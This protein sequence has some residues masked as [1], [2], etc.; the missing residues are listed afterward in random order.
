MILTSGKLYDSSLQGEILNG[1]ERKINETRERETLQAETV[2]AAVEVLREKILSGEFDERIDK[3]A[4]SGAYGAENLRGQIAQALELLKRENLEYKL[5]VELGLGTGGP[6]EQKSTIR[7]HVLP[8]GTLF[9]IAAGNMDGLPVYS[10]LEGLLTGN[11]NILKLPQADGGLSVEILLELLQIEPGLAPYIHVFD[12]P[13]EDIAAMQKMADMSDGIVVWGGDEA[14]KAVRRL[15][16]PGAKLIEW[17]HRLGFAYLSGYED[18]ERELT[19]L[20]GHIARTRQLL[21]SSCQVIFIDTEEMEEVYGFCQEFLPYLQ[22]AVDELGQREEETVGTRAEIALR[23]Y[24][25]MIDRVLAEGPQEKKAEKRGVY[26][27]R[28]CS[29]TALPDSALECSYLFGNCLVK[30]LPRSRIFT[31]LRRYKGYLQTVGLVCDRDRR[32]ELTELFAACG[33][34]RIMRAGS[35]SDAFVGE[36]HDGEYA[37]RRYV[38]MVD[39]EL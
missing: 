11:V 33:L 37:L 25:D 5:Q 38:R 34:V 30:R 35:Q 21:C 2:I 36:A 19:A 32:E 14:V 22:R 24:G 18:R 6:S 20:A 27:G 29:L 7:T 13:S 17:G 12:T 15:A 16:N 4:D 10:V 9:H 39:V 31:Q 26:Y 28:G 1:L 3:L 8:L 23:R